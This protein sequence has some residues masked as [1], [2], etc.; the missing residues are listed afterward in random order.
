[1]HSK[2]RGAHSELTACL[3]LLE[4]GYEVFRNISQHGIAD[5]VA[6]RGNEILK[7][8]VK[9][10]GPMGQGRQRPDED[11]AVIYVRDGNCK[12]DL[13]KKGTGNEQ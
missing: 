13:R 3:W 12:L 4:Q 7:I 8:D 6:F 11:V 1:M 2:H 10:L 9:T 5:V